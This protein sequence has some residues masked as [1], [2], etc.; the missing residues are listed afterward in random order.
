M[1]R[2]V[3]NPTSGE[4]TIQ[5]LLAEEGMVTLELYSSTG[6]LL[7]KIDHGVKGT[8]AHSLSYNARSL[9]AGTY[10][11]RLTVGKKVFSAP[12]TVQ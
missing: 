4:A 9:G 11:L 7:R 2:S 10:F 12:M 3:P 5:Y 8:G 6:E 1:L